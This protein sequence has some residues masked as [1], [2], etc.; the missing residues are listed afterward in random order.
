MDSRAEKD[1]DAIQGDV[2]VYGY[3]KYHTFSAKG[4]SAV[5]V[6]MREAG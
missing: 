4:R 1:N 5:H 2:N 6:S 3:E